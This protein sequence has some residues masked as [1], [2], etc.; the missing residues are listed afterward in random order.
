MP[1]ETPNPTIAA[2]AADVMILKFDT[3]N[4]PFSEA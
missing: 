3:V 4:S 2:I 1:D